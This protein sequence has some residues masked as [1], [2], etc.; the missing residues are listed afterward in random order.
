M[1]TAICDDERCPYLL[2][3]SAGDE[4]FYL[5]DLNDKPCLLEYDDGC[6]I[7]DD[8]LRELEAED[9]ETKP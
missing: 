3:K 8:Y 1:T 2:V 4:A 7:Y 6:P 9:A 5:C